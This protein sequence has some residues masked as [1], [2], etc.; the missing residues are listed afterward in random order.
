VCDD[1]L[2]GSQLQGPLLHCPRCQTDFDVIHAGAVVSD[3]S[4][5]HLDPIPLLTRD[6]QLSVALRHEAIGAPT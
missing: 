5:G 3:E 1:S 4:S 6:G 2:A